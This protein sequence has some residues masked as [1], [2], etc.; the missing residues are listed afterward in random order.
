MQIPSSSLTC[1]TF[2]STFPRRERPFITETIAPAALFL[3][4]FP[5]RERPVTC[6][7]LHL[8]TTHFY[9]RSHVG[10]DI[11]GLGTAYFQEIFLSTFPRRERPSVS[12]CCRVI[13]VFLSTFPRRERR[14]PHIS[15]HTASDFYPRS[16]VGNDYFLRHIRRRRLYF[17]P[18]SHVGNDGIRLLSIHHKI[19]DFYPRSHVGNDPKSPASSHCLIISIHVPT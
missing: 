7:L 19:E 4:T 14:V 2:L 8:R 10:N 11:A 3:S 12:R 9:P 13:L 5:R 1:W 18:R 6:S 15:V 17:Y 16:H